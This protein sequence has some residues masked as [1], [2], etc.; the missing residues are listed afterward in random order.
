[1]NVDSRPITAAGWAMLHR[2]AEGDTDMLARLLGY[3]CDPAAHDGS[4]RWQFM[5]LAESNGWKAV[6]LL[7]LRKMIERRVSEGKLDAW[8]E[9]TPLGEEIRD[10]LMSFFDSHRSVEFPSEPPSFGA[11]AFQELRA[12]RLAGELC[13]EQQNPAANNPDEIMERLAARL[14]DRFPLLSQAI[15]H[16]RLDL[17]AMTWAILDL[18]IRFNFET[19]VALPTS[20][21]PPSNVGLE[22]LVVLFINCPSRV[23]ELIGDVYA[24]GE[25]I[26]RVK[27]A[28][29]RKGI[30]DKS[31]DDLK[32]EARDEVKAMLG[33]SIPIHATTLAEAVA[34][35]EKIRAT[36]NVLVAINSLWAWFNGLPALERDRIGTF[37]NAR[38]FWMTARFRKRPQ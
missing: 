26:R 7:L 17:P 24:D 38:D 35:S 20:R 25:Y 31:D 32:R 37:K 21:T 34:E 1:M 9:T 2:M 28:V 23:E 36:E 19:L 22:D 18:R 3:F 27:L 29:M 15:R 4:E 33:R 11:L 6:E 8:V 5:R 10:S 16:Q 14:A 13:A 12:A 30:V